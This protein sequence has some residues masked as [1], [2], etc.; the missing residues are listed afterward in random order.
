M[1]LTEEIAR[2]AI[3]CLDANWDGYGANPVT[4]DTVNIACK[5]V[6]SLSPYQRPDSAAPEPD[7]GIS[8]DWYKHPRWV[9]SISIIEG[10][11]LAY[12]AIFGN[13]TEHGTAK[14][15]G[16]DKFPGV[17]IEIRQIINRFKNEPPSP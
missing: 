7:G 8:F 9:L 3:E 12:A 11:G 5:F 6:G 10:G 1:S 13:H 4:P 17:P 14:L 15:V 2:I 16:T